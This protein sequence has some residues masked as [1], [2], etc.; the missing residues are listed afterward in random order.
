MADY[1]PSDMVRVSYRGKVYAGVILSYSAA[2]N[3]YDVQ[4]TYE[5]RNIVVTLPASNVWKK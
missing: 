4:I 1:S 3:T 2:N 5:G